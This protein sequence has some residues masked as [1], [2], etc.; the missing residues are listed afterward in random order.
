MQHFRFVN[1]KIGKF[2]FWCYNQW[3]MKPWFILGFIDLSTCIIIEKKTDLLKLI[4]TSYITV[5]KVWVTENLTKHSSVLL[6]RL[7]RFS[8]TQT[9]LQFVLNPGLLDLIIKVINITYGPETKWRK[10][11]GLDLNF[12]LLRIMENRWSEQQLNNNIPL[13]SLS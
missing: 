12:F 2:K 13:W 7:V 1:W 8:T 4:V 9:L 3:R 11:W 5:Y 10:F 6:L